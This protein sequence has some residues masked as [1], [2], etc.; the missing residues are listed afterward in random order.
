MSEAFTDADGVQAYVG[1]A[2]NRCVRLRHQIMPHRIDQHESQ[3][4]IRLSQPSATSATCRTASSR[5]KTTSGR[6]ERRRK[7]LGVRT[8][9]LL[10]RFRSRQLGAILP[11]FIYARPRCDQTARTADRAVL[12]ELTWFLALIRVT[13]SLPSRQDVII[14]APL[15]HCESWPSARTDRRVA[16]P[17]RIPDT[18]SRR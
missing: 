7:P 2:K 16:R 8:V 3:F 14:A 11:R 9:F 6:T 13:D 17:S 10:C 4:P 18:A 15:A 12:V 5:T 1:E